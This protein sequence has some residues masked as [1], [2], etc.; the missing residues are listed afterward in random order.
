MIV[1]TFE[2][3][4]TLVSKVFDYYYAACFNHDLRCK[5]QKEA[6]SPTAINGF[7]R[8]GFYAKWNFHAHAFTPQV[9]K[10]YI[11]LYDN[12]FAHVA[13]HMAAHGP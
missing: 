4:H 7:N 9:L 6:G 11:P 12:S 5:P 1:Y 2:G 10:N 8:Y 3:L 13:K